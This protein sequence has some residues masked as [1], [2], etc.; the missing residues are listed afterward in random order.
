MVVRGPA[1]RYQ[2]YMLRFWET[3]VAQPGCPSSWRF[4]LEDPHTRERHGFADLEAMT[5]FL[6]DLIGGKDLSGFR[7]PEGSGLN[8]ENK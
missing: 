8:T 2:A 6:R 4:S 1:P 5:A 7:K 3:Q